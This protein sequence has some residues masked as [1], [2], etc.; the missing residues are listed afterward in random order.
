MRCASVLSS[1][2]CTVCARYN[3]KGITIPEIS[4]TDLGNLHARH[5]T[6]GGSITYE[7]EAKTFNYNC[8]IRPSADVMDVEEAG[9]CG[10][11]VE[12]GAEL[13]CT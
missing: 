6:Q 13:M 8:C 5:R 4:V 3:S 2:G 10:C 9:V 11:F 1:G 12:A 7:F